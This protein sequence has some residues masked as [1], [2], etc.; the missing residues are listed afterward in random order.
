MCMMILFLIVNLLVCVLSV[1]VLSLGDLFP[2]LRERACLPPH[3]PL[4]LFEVRWG[5]AVGGARGKGLFATAH[6]PIAL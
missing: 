3:T 6:S 4:I 5:G 1:C 2:L